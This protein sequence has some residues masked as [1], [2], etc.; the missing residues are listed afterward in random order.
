M[1]VYDSYIV[2]LR[3]NRLAVKALLDNLN[4]DRVELQ[5]PMECEDLVL[6]KYTLKSSI[7]WM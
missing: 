7:R 5:A 3:G 4:L 1:L 6:A 2:Q